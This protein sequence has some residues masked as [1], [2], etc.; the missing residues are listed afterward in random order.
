[1]KALIHCS[2]TVK[3]KKNQLLGISRIEIKTEHYYTTLNIYSSA[4]F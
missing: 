2:I 1:M 3:K 4:V